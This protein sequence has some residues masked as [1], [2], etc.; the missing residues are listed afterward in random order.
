LGT[1]G[2][3]LV[4]CHWIPPKF[5][6]I[7]ENTVK[8]VRIHTAFIRQQCDQNSV[9]D[10]KLSPSSSRILN[11][12]GNRHSTYRNPYSFNSAKNATRIRL[13]TLNEY[14]TLQLK[15]K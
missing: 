15:K 5:S 9:R 12:S 4:G 3:I 7:R 13:G 6:T 11:N 14:R 2:V 10:R 1:P 8:K